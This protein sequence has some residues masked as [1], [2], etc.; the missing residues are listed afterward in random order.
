MANSYSATPLT[1]SD[2]DVQYI[3][4]RGLIGG[5]VGK[6]NQILEGLQVELWTRQQ[7]PGHL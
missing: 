1:S 7:R 6:E 2:A 3:V 5:S 4:T